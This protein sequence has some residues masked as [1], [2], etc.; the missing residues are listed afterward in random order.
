M[1]IV[2]SVH[3]YGPKAQNSTG[4]EQALIKYQLNEQT[5]SPG[6]AKWGCDG[7]LNVNWGSVRGRVKWVL[8]RVQA[9][10]RGCTPLLPTPQITPSTSQTQDQVQDQAVGGG[11]AQGG[12][13]RR[14]TKHT[15]P[16]LSQVLYFPEVMAKR[17]WG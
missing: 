12:E 3:C 16:A 15:A 1:Y 2:C 8:R 5:D 9:N 14:Q 11:G 7:T 4:T 6:P 10:R 13:Q 17:G